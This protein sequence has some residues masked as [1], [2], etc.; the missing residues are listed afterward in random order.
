MV[1]QSPLT[2]SQDVTLLKTIPTE[3][4]IQ[5]W[6]NSFGIDITEEVYE[7]ENIYFY[8]CNETQLKFFVPTQTVGSAKLY[9]HLQKFEWYYM[10][11]KWEHDVAIQDL[12]NCHKILEVGC[13]K[14]AF[15]ERLRKELKVDAQGIE[16]NSSAVAYACEKGIPVSQDDLYD[17]SNQ[18]ANY[19]DAVCTFQVLEHVVEPQ[20]FFSSLVELVKPGGKL[21]I[22]VPNSKSFAKYSENNLLEQPPHHMTQ[23]CRDTFNQIT[24]IY[25]IQVVNFRFESLAEYHVDWYISVQL[26]RL[27]K[28]RLLNSLCFRFARHILKPALKNFSPLRKLIRGHTIY[29]CYQKNA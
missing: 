23:W 3:K 17:L 16:L 7:H 11:Q 8:K 12:N 28:I 27:P 29:V 20:N 19:F 15:V 4:L 10:P 1:P 22:A 13:G 2:N 9:E 14:G 5:D 26:S 21:I 25:P 18:K 24:S 6:K